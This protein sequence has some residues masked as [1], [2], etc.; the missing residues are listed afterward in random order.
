MNLKPVSYVLRIG[1]R[2]ERDQ[3]VTTHV[4]L[5]SRALGASGMYL[6]ADDQKVSDSI[7]DVAQRFGGDYFC[8]NNVKWKSFIRKFK[9]DGGKVVHLTM[10]GLRLQDAIPDIRKE[11]KVLVVVGAEKVPGEMY[12]LADYN[13]AVANQPHSEISALALFLDHLYEG[14]ELEL[15]FDNPDIEVIP[16]KVGKTTIKHG[17]PHE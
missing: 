2:P 7:C 1:H 10:Y 6:A 15:S 8:E 3:R 4:G 13:V 9:A 17:Q 5:S 12:E 16:T 11:E 14:R